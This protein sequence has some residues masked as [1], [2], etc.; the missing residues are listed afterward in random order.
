M[1]TPLEK[2]CIPANSVSLCWRAGGR[3]RACFGVCAPVSRGALPRCHLQPDKP[4]DLSPGE[5]PLSGG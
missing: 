1:A 5:L 2:M 3:L 4:K